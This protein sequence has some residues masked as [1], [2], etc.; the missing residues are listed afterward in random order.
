MRARFISRGHTLAAILGVAATTIVL[1]VVMTRVGAA[2]GDPVT[3]RPT[4]GRKGR[5]VE[6]PRGKELLFLFLQRLADYTGKATYF[7]GST[8]PDATITLKREV[9]QLDFETARS[10]L[11]DAGY[12]LTRQNHRQQD[13]LWIQKLLTRP[14][15]RGKL[16]RRRPGDPEPSPV[17]AATASTPAG[18]SLFERRDGAGKRFLIT[19]ETSS[20]EETDDLL[21]LL[22]AF[23]KKQIGR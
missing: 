19:F 10:V 17:S 20:R 16:T 3:F 1:P 6:I 7:V 18:V 14:G 22:E 11:V 5:A 2:G 12:E 9:Q 13:V 8:A 21:L 23:Q 4:E 15:G